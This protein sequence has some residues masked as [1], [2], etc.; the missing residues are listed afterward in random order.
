[1]L[2]STRHLVD[3]NV[4]DRTH[5]LYVPSSSCRRPTWSVIYVHTMAKNRL[6]ALCV[7]VHLRK[8]TIWRHI[9]ERTR[10]NDR[11]AAATA[12]SPSRSRATWRSTRDITWTQTRDHHVNTSVPTARND[13]PTT[14]F[15]APIYEFTLVNARLLVTGATSNSR[16][17]QISEDIIGYIQ[18]INRLSALNVTRRFRRI[19]I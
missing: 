13:L 9:C 1:M 3:Y 2:R 5:V 15:S 14:P 4:N 6:H 7:T 18:A 11:S 16:R 17:N 12:I 8:R 19:I 10:E